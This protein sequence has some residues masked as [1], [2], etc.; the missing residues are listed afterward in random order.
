MADGGIDLREISYSQLFPW[1]RLF[2][3][4]GIAVDGKKMLLAAFGLVLMWVG[5]EGLDLL[6]PGSPEI[7]PDLAPQ[8]PVIHRLV[9]IEPLA[10][11][12]EAVSDPIRTPASPFLTLFE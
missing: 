7:T 2:R 3:N 4:F 6:F 1:I 10:T 5:W 11:A 12:V 9:G 8:V